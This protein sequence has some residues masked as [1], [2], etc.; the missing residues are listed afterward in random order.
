MI[1]NYILPI[2][3]F[4]CSIQLSFGQC[5]VSISPS[6]PQSI[7]NGSS[8]TL[9]ASGTGINNY[10]WSPAAGLSNVGIPNPVAT[11]TVTT[12]YTVLANCGGGGGGNTGTATITVTVNP[13][14][15]VPNITIYK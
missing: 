10:T 9:T 7:C 14:P 3:L 6:S 11:S 1:K 8:I 4:I 5:T 12:T 15:N 2:L 13:L